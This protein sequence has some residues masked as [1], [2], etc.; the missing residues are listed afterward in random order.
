MKQ[1]KFIFI[2]LVFFTFSS[3]AQT[4]KEKKEIYQT[5]I[6]AFANNN[7]P[8][9]NETLTRIYNYDIDGNFDKWFYQRDN[10]QSPDT[11][12]FAGRL[13]CVNPIEY[14][15]TVIA[16]LKSQNIKEG[17]FSYQTDNLKL[18]SLSNYISN[19]RIISWKKA[20][21]SNSFFRNIFK[22]KQ[23]IG[24][25]DVLFNENNNLATVKIQV[26]AKNKLRSKNPSKIIV[27]NKDGSD[28]KI[29]GSL[30]EKQPTNSS[31]I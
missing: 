13:I 27:L 6:R 23:V 11:F 9:I 18:D 1:F 25:S 31:G 5:V 22:K 28:W 20:P 7:L 4:V 10:Q 14:D 21:L 2:T 19:S 15:E 3:S 24:L 29:I 16:F 26:Y 8:L 12:G 30:D 17:D